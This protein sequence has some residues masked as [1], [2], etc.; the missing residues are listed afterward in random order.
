MKIKKINILL[1]L[2]LGACLGFLGCS[3]D[4]GGIPKRVQ[5]AE[6]PVIS[7]NLAGGGLSTTQTFT[8]T[9]QGAFTGSF[10]VK[11]WFAG[12]TPPTKIDIAVRKNN[13]PAATSQI[14]NSNV[15]VFK[16]DITSLPASFTITAADLVALFG[17]IALNDAFD[18]GPDIYVGSTKYQAFPAAVGGIAVTG[19]GSG[20]VGQHGYGDFVRFWAR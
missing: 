17:P 20:V 19:N 10:S 9:N 2:T 14:N 16:A 12:A 11:L 8:F 3:K 4:D 7:T 15:K 1:T 18:F 6:V 5:V 13:M